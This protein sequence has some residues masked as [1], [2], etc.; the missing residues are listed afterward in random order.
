ME[1][2]FCPCPIGLEAS[3]STE[4][5][6]L[7][8][9][10]IITTG[11]GVAW[12]GTL[13]Q[14]M[15]VNLHSRIASRVL[16][17][18]GRGDYVEAQ[19]VYAGAVCLPWEEWL[20]SSQTIRVDTHA[21]LCPLKSLDF[22]TLLVKDALCDRL[23]E[24]GGSRPS[25]D[26]QNPDHRVFVYLTQARYN[27]Y[28]DTTGS[29][30]FR[31]GQRP[32][33]GIAPL[34]KNLA[35]GLLSL[36]GW[37]GQEP[38]LDPFCGTGTILLEAAD[39]AQHRAS[40]LGRSFAFQKIQNWPVASWASYQAEAEE[41]VRPLIEGLLW[42]YDGKGDAVAQAQMNSE[43][44]GLT[45]GIR[46]KQVNFKESKA[47]APT[48]CIVTNPPYGVRLGEQD[49]LAQ[50]YVD[51]GDVLKQKYAGWRAYFLTADRLFERRVRLKVSKR[52]VL[53]NGD[54]DCRLYEIIIRGGSYR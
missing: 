16:W 39:I 12:L 32:E 36:A 41:S 10:S 49:Q 33:R 6:S 26:T 35:A 25:V 47:P 5:G 11:G 28:L 29:G 30:L 23:R 4:L 17:L 54:L 44:A 37:S 2:F 9:Q 46:F 7:N 27:I 22:V 18:V 50:E 14:A 34:K 52:M 45:S 13:E 42:G 48:G 31:R 38:L 53:K 15:Q 51:W 20:I 1:S 43:V 21:H 40:G 24:Q 3:L 19:D 8:L